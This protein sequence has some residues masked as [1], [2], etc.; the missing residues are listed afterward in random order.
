MKLSLKQEMLR[1]QVGEYAKRF[2]FLQLEHD[3]VSQC[4]AVLDRLFKQN[5]CS[6]SDALLEI[7]TKAEADLDRWF[8]MEGAIPHHT[9]V[10]RALFMTLALAWGFVTLIPI[11]AQATIVLLCCLIFLMLSG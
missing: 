3:E 6:S 8:Q 1:W 10:L 5:D 2:R 9:P 4:L 11:A 7:V